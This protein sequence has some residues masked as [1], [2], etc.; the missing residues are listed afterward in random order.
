MITTRPQ[1][2]VISSR[3]LIGHALRMTQATDKTFELWSGFMP[4]KKKIRKQIN[5]DLYSFQIYDTPM[6]FD[7]FNPTVEFK[8]WAAIE[9]ENFNHVP[10]GMETFVLPGGKYAVFIHQGLASDF[11]KTMNYIFKKWLPGSDYEIDDRIIFALMGE[12]YK[13]NDPTSEEEIWIPIIEKN[14][15]VF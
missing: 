1:I 12:K 11:G 14:Y 6:S 15:N 2:K 13:N 5:K 7:K 9:V 3:N 8:K 10:D 4:N